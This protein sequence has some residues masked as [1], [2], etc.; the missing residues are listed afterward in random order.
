MSALILCAECKIEFPKD[1]LVDIKG[2]LICA[3]C[4]PIVIQRVEEYGKTYED[5]VTA[6][7]WIRFAAFVLDSFIVTGFVG[8]IGVIITLSF[9]DAMKLEYVILGGI[10]LSQYIVYPIYCIIL[11]GKY[12]V[13]LGKKIVGIKVIRMDGSPLGFG[14]AI[15]RFFAFV[16]SFSVMYIGCIMAA[17]DKKHA[18]ALHDMIC[19]TRVVYV[20]K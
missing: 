20:K 2:S 16:L 12:S 7:F 14:L 18:K 13:T 8:I 15:G 1:D 10:V 19:N 11:L 9:P 3:S 6:G 17:F 5:F 4:K